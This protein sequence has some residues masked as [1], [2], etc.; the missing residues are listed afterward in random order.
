MKYGIIFAII[1]LSACP[2]DKPKA[3][4]KK[5]TPKVE[6]I[7]EK[8]PEKAIEKVI[9]KMPLRLSTGGVGK[10]GAASAFDLKT[11][12]TAFEGYTVTSSENSMEGEVYKIFLVKENGTVMLEIAGTDD[13][14][15]VGEILAKNPKVKNENGTTVGAI[16]KDIFPNKKDADCIM[17]ADD[18]G[19]TY[20]CKIPKTKN[21]R[22]RFESNIQ[23]K[24][25]PSDDW[26][27][28]SIEWKP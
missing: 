27:L 24:Y 7:V 1:C 14:K 23:G 13:G 16:F 25:K 2:A 20:M 9:K 6:K 22:Y 19:E 17:G 28:R 18:L 4:P 10:L 11:I 5:D 8:V 26:I 3:E 21:L 12:Q 15:K